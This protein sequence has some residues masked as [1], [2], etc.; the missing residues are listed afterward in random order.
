[1]KASAP[2]TFSCPVDVP[3]EVLG[4]KW[5]LILV[6]HMLGGPRRNG[7]LLRLV[8]GIAQK[9]LTQ[10]LRDLER[11]GIVVRAVH[12]EVPPKVVYSLDPG[13]RERLEPLLK[14]LCDWSDYW[15]SRAGVGVD[16][17]ARTQES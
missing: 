10:Q 7:E 8:P 14:A 2:R 5:K 9:M 4:G 11:D 3:I 15:T 17:S 12:H 1:M 16:R 13:E 6:F